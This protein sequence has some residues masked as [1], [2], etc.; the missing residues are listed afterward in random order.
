MALRPLRALIVKNAPLPPTALGERAEL[1]LL[2]LD[3][4]VVDD[5]YQRNI[6]ENGRRNILRILGGFDWRKFMPVVCMPIENGLYAIIDGQHRATAALMHPAIDMVPCMVIK[7]SVEE[8]ASVFAAINGQ[9]T[10]ITAQQIFYA[11]VVAGEATANALQEVLDIAEVKVLKNKV[12][13]QPYRPGETLAIGTLE[14]CLRD[15]GRD[16]LITALQAITQS[17]DGNAG[18]LV[19]P[20]IA[21]MCSLLHEVGYWRES[22]SKL[23]AAM[24]ELDLL[25]F[26]A[27]DR[28]SVV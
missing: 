27:E 1:C 18:C 6:T 12:P 4:L 25:D 15:Y 17:G 26:I 7:V 11:R 28:K 13:G 16:T 2:P 23:F 10:A 24:D 14:K 8:A 22:G 20:F 21:A 9:V 3:R 19:A 5:R